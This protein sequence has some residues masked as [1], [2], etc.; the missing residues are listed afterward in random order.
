MKENEYEK[1]LHY[2]WTGRS[3]AG[4]WGEKLFYRF[5]NLYG[6]ILTY[7][8][9]AASV[10]F[11]LSF[12]KR[13]RNASF[14]FFSRVYGTSNRLRLLWHTSCQFWCWGACWADRSF[15]FGGG[16]K[17]YRFNREGTRYFEEA[18]RSKKGLFVITAHVGNYEL[19]AWMLRRDS[20][21]VVNIALIDDEERR[22]RRFLDQMQGEYRPRIIRL[23]RSSF[24]S[25]AVLKALREGEIV[26]IQAD[27]VVDK[28]AIAVDFFGFKALFPKGPLTLSLATGAPILI[29]FTLKRGWNRYVIVIDKP[30]FP[31]ENSS[32]RE[33]ALRDLAEKV[34]LHIEEIVRRHPH[35]WFNFYPYWIDSPGFQQPN[36]FN[37]GQL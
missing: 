16:I 6:R 19:G 9:I 23:S 1:R 7:G 2:P 37:H 35:Q 34:A 21:L 17:R 22:V 30:I 29:T 27:R 8:A 18:L 10:P 26:G 25:I 11:F 3:L 20:G 33:P 5:C 28:N 12:R 24:S 14:D 31:P 4:L 36:P 32:D 13:V 15:I